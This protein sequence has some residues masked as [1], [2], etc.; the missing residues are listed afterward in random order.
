VALDLVLLKL[1]QLRRLVPFAELVARVERLAG[2]APAAP[3]PAARPTSPRARSLPDV[4]AAAPPAPRAASRAE[5][6]APAA[7]APAVPARGPGDSLLATMIG[8]GQGRPSLQAPLRAAFA[9]LEGD[10]LLVEVPA[11][12]VTFATMHADEYRDLARKAA[13]RTLHVEIAAAAAAANPA[14]PSSPEEARRQTLRGEVEKERAVQEALDLFDGRVVEVR[15]A[16][17]SGEDL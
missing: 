10:K 5:E 7:P 4:P 15:E 3:P 8:H 17:P 6:P 2:G 11:E 13:G 1:V 14:A 12:Y 9:R 16:K